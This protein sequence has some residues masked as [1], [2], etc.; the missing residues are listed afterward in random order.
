ME[1]ILNN[2][3][4]EHAIKFRNDLKEKL[5]SLYLCDNERSTDLFNF[6]DNYEQLLFDKKD[7]LKPKRIKIE[8]P[9]YHRCLAK[10]LNGDQC[11]RRKKKGCEYC[12]THTKSMPYGIYEFKNENTDNEKKT[13]NVL[14]Q[15]IQGIIYYIDEYLNVYDTQQVI[16]EIENP[17]IIAKAIKTNGIYTI[18][19]LGL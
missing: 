2:R 15:D 19:E 18:P 10:R 14:A 11:T 1:K 17:E 4:K 16:E 3:I 12:G 5:A 7:I 8:L 9:I 6:I 13:L